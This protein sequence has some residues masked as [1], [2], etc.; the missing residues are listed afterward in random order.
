MFASY[1]LKITK[2]DYRYTFGKIFLDLHYLFTEFDHVKGT[3]LME[4]T[5]KTLQEHISEIE[6]EEKVIFD[7][8]LIALKKVLEFKEVKLTNPDYQELVEEHIEEV[9]RRLTDI[10]YGKLFI[11]E[12]KETDEGTELEEK[13]F[14]LVDDS[15]PNTVFE[16]YVENQTVSDKLRAITLYLTE[17]NGLIE[18]DKKEQGA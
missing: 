8:W 9:C 3:F 17:I 4:K 15:D 2:L 16:T 10:Y 18:L 12:L 6:K 13:F 1:K 11:A 5:N 14:D 7:D